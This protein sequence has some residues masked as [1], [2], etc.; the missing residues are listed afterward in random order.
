V[1]AD[2]NRAV[3]AGG[4]VVTKTL[5][6]GRYIHLV[7]DKSGHWHAGEVRTKKGQ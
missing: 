2:F 6:K 7:K 3:K 4:K 5:S 1:P